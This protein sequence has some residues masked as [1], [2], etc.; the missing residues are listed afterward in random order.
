[1]LTK[2]ASYHGYFRQIYCIP[3]PC[4]RGKMLRKLS[5]TPVKRCAPN[6]SSFLRNT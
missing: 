4:E 3:E 5:M 6:H 2:E 1:M